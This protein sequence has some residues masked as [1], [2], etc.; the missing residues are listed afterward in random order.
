MKNKNKIN[1][2]VITPD[3]AQEVVCGPIESVKIHVILNPAG[4]M[5]T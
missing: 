4:Y 1:L 5:L 3:N 2:V